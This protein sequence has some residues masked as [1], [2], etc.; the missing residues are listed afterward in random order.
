M[1]I[2]L[3]EISLPFRQ[4]LYQEK[5]KTEKLKDKFK[6]CDERTD[7]VLDEREKSLK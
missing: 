2:L 3:M 5:T 7:D 1:I 6:I 4:G